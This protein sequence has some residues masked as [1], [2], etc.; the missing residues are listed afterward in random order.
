MQIAIIQDKITFEQISSTRQLHLLQSWSWGQI[1]TP[2]TRVVVELDSQSYVLTIHH[3]SIAKLLKFGYLP[4]VRIAR[5]DLL[6]VVKALKQFA[7]QNH[8]A[9]LLL[10]FDVS[11]E[12]FDSYEASGILPVGK[13][14]QP[15]YTNQITL[16]GKSVED[17]WQNIKSKYRRNINKAQKSGV[18]V[19]AYTHG[20]EPLNNFFT[21]MQQIFKNTKYVG[22]D[23][24]YFTKVWK[25]L[26]E[27]SSAKIFIAKYQDQIVGSYLVAYDMEGAYELYGGVS[28]SG[29]DMEAGYLL[30]WR[31]IEDAKMMGKMIYDHWGVAKRLENG[32]YDAKDELYNISNFK[33]G[34]GGEYIEFA[35]QQ[36]LIIDAKAFS[37]Y[38][39]A[40]NAKQAW[41]QIKKYK[42]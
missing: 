10:E 42:V 1:K 6:L 2:I 23:Q 30:K 18:Q 27:S 8:L 20:D 9:F 14:I 32:N 4:K 41:L 31:A 7:Q 40:A 24:G 5:H 21:I 28:K 29:R 33:E 17:L 35:P 13:T 25:E 11:K 36:A 26:S 16:E 39:L 34:F 37:L 15:Q 19:A 12:Q 22:Y 3:K 38:K